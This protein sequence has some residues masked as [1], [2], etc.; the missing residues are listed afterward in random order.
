[1][2]PKTVI[3]LLKA[4]F[5]AV[6]LI[7]LMQTVFTLAGGQKATVS[8]SLFSLQFPLELTDEAAVRSLGLYVLACALPLYALCF[9]VI[10]KL[11]RILRPLAD[12]GSPFT[13]ESVAG[14]RSIGLAL[15][16]YAAVK[17]AVEAAGG[18]IIVHAGLPGLSQLNSMIA[19]P[20]NE[21]IAGAIVLA[22]AGIFAH[23]LALKQDNDSIV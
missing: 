11:I 8:A 14:V 9:F 12:G 17:M 7:C 21:F 13:A 6:I 2:R 4:V 18:Y 5:V 19:F 20:V 15:W 16:I 22:L 3:G 10:V 23:G 1:M